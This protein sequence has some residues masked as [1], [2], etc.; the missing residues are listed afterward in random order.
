MKA[1]LDTSALIYL[2]DFRPFDKVLT[3]SG[4]VQ[5]VKDKITA[6]KLS[7]IDLKVTEPSGRSMQEVEKV[8]KET[9]D[10]EK[11][12]GTDKK[13]LALANDFKKEK[14]VIISDDRNVQNVAEKLG[15]KY[16]SIFNRRITKLIKWGKY[17]KNCDKYY[18][19]DEVCKICGA[20]LKRVPVSSKSLGN[21]T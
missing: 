13:V 21:R 2:N 18:E 16:I 7:A 15:I 4:V 6:M 8:A 1:I 19:K 5:E 3:V 20:R 10:I 11:L 14:Y 9:G 12:S 17:C